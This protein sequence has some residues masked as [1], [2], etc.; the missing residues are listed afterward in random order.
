MTRRCSIPAMIMGLCLAT[1]SDTKRKPTPF[2][3]LKALRTFSNLCATNLKKDLTQYAQSL[4]FER[5]GVMKAERLV[6]EEAHLKR[7]I[8]EGRAGE[9]DYMTKDPER[10]ARPAE[11]LSGAKSVISLA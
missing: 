6:A 1:R 5:F 4:G 7:W 11:L 10:R 8:S 9:M 2:S 3:W